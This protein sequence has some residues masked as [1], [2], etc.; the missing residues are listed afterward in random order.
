MENINVLIVEDKKSVVEDLERRLKELEYS[1]CAAVPSGAEA[2]EKAAEMQPDVV[3][4]NVELEGEIDGIETAKQ[5]RDS[6]DIPTVYLAD[7]SNDAFVEKK[8]LLKRAEITNPFDYI[9]LPHGRRRMYLTVEST[10]YQHKME[11]ETKLKE[12][13]LS[14]ILNSIS[15][16]VIA[17]DNQ[18][19]VTFMNPAA[20]RLTGWQ[21]EEAASV[22]IKQIF[23]IDNEEGCPITAILKNILNTDPAVSPESPT[24]VE[25]KDSTVFTSKS[26]RKTHIDYSIAPSIN[27]KGKVVGTVITFRDI[28]GQ[29]ALE[30]RLNQTIDQ[31]Q[32]QTQL[33]ETIFDSMSDG[34]IAAD[35]A[36]RYLMTNPKAKEITGI[37][38]EG[39]EDIPIA[40]R[41]ERYGLF[42]PDGKTLFSEDE[43]P[44]IRACRGETIDNIEMV[45]SNDTEA[46][47]IINVNGRPLLDGQGNLTGGVIVLRD[48]TELKIAQTKLE[49][50]VSEARNQSQLMETIFNSISDGVMAVDTDGKYLM[51]NARV[52]E[53]VGPL[54]E[55]IPI[56][57]RPKHYGLFYPDGKTLF[58]GDELPI[59]RALRGETTNNIEILVS[60]DSRA[61]RIININGRPLLDEQG[62]LKG[63]VIVCRDTTELKAAQTKLEQTV[64]E[65]RDKTQLIE[66]V[67]D[68]MSDGIAVIGVTGQVMLVNPSIKRMLGTRPVDKLP[69]NWSEAYGVFYPDKERHIPIDQFLS[70]HIFRGEAI[71]DKEIFVRNEGQTDGIHVMASALPLFGENREVIGCVAILRDI[72]ESKI[73]EARLEQTMQEL[74][75]QVQ[76]T[77]IVFNSISDGVVVTDEAGNFLLVNPSAE[78]IVGMGPTDT[79]PDQWSDAYGT[80]YP[81]KVTPFP[82]E[83][84]PLIKAMQG[85]VTDEIDLFMRNPENPEGCFINV[86]G[87]PLQDERNRVRGGVIV[88]RD[89]TKAKNTEVRLEQTIG[90]LE[91]QTQLL[92]TVFNSM[93]DGVV[94]LDTTGQ[95]LFTN[96]S[97]ELA[98]IESPRNVDSSEWPETYGIFY[99]DQETPVPTDQMPVMRALRG[100]EIEDEEFF[101]RNIHNNIRDRFLTDGLFVAASASPLLDK[102]QQIIGSVG[103]VRDITEQKIATIQLQQTMQ[104]LQDQTQLMDTIFNNMSDGVVVADE[105]GEYIMANP[106]AEKV[107]GQ[108]LEPL[109]LPRASEQYGVFHST[110]KSLFP[111]DQLPLAQAVKGEAANNVEMRVNNEHLSQ[112]VYISV[113]GRPLLDEQGV[114]RG[115]VVVIRDVT[116]LKQTQIQLENQTQLLE[117]VFN[118]MSDGVIVADENGE[119]IMANPAAEQM[120]GQGYDAL[121]LDQSS[122]QYG[123]FDPTT[124]SLFTPDR[125]PLTRAVKGEATDN[126]EMCIRNPHL[127]QE[128]YVSVNGRP[129]LDEQGVSRGGLVVAHNIT[130]LKQIQ[131]QLENQTQLLETIFN[132]M[133]DGVVVADEN[134]EYIMANP[135]AEQMNGQPFDELDLPRA[136]EQYGVFDPTTGSLFPPDQLPLTRAVRG[137][138][139]N[140]VEMQVK[141]EY[142][143]DIYLSINGRPLLDEKGVSRGGVVVAHNITEL[144]QTQLQL[145]QTVTELEN[146]TQL[147]EIVFN[148]MSDGVVVADDK[149]QYVMYNQTA[150]RMTGQQLAPMAIKDAPKHFGFFFP[151]KKTTFPADQLP[152]ARAL[153]G[154]GTDNVNLFMYNSK[155]QEGLH[156]S[157]SARPLRNA[158]GVVTGGVSVSRDVTKLRQAEI[159]LQDLVRQLEE[160]GN[161]MESIF[162]SISDGVVVA[163][164]DG[165]F[166]IFNPSAEKIVGLGAVD[167]TSDHWSDAYGLFFPDRVTPFPSEE[168]P[169]SLALQGETSDDVEMFVRNPN[170]PDGVFI[171]VSGRP[172][173]DETGTDKGGVAV[174]RDVTHRVIA[175]EAL[176]QA[177]AQGRLEIVET[178]LHNIGNAINSVTVGMNVLQETLVGNQLI[179]RFSALADMVKAH[180]EDWADFIKNDPKGQ[181]VLPFMIALAADFTDQNERV[182]KTLER[183]G[184]RVTHIIDII[185]T[186]RSSNQSSMVR[187]TIDLQQAILGAVKLQQ[188]S[189]D[190]RGIQVDVDCENAP[191]EI[192]IQESQF[193]Q[194]LVNL[195]KN[196]VEAIDDRIRSDGPNETPRIEIK[197]YTDADFLCLDVTDNGI[198]IAPKDLKLIFNA[199]YTTKELGTGLGLHSSANFVIGSGGKIQPLSE[200][201]GKG[202]TMRIMMRCSSI[203]P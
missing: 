185:R 127:S 31:L 159:E 1:V 75:N 131:I 157:T 143:N 167:T 186:Q 69:S 20:E 132:S 182:V 23:R 37:S 87:R 14:T 197:A 190:K 46:E 4:I 85:Q 188:D 146:Q 163:D 32:D 49:Q 110:T 196:S 105:N 151:D 98:C 125:L 152:L 21:L 92:D 162:N 3:L 191:Q 24:D 58:P 153:R 189:I 133:S 5:I 136:S 118:S 91:R 13:Q 52:E 35:T 165:A 120:T 90:S 175:E 19:L 184:E 26:G 8:D 79:P 41:S 78:R 117:T 160:Q 27:Q 121:D 166:T 43:L 15:D 82:N 40:E 29:K 70:T 172:I 84:L 73:A 173:R 9:P 183:V 156:L 107:V 61:E 57:D 169:L 6:L 119:Y 106:A 101:I 47:R 164:E 25:V 86:T 150:E 28:T 66:T 140:N 129:L 114:S 126:I 2:V 168:L 17:T 34:M 18:E 99:V 55:D 11:R 39:L 138:S 158:Q 142:S 104:E 195:L 141:N 56:T 194:M 137:E 62:N 60:N 95:V 111:S 68:T 65:L 30:E 176:M 115:G 64:S 201:I 89:V 76:L 149:G 51:V 48:M 112:E 33:M 80:F 97:V 67:F 187:K 122:E 123:L 36:G 93:N 192:K 128:V 50:A 178:I 154:E 200:G 139:T 88:F 108:S 203:M 202:A 94:V 22:S 44:L 53:M 72:T 81:D 77:E 199:G 59:T 109:D 130:E 181:Q 103:I 179:N 10:V 54:S 180:Q 193:Q 83:E 102:D 148:N 135:A 71:R 100:E 12:Q 174:F 7:Y 74:Q 171:S 116:E 16:A 134:G 147:L 155:M 144:K 96:S 161:L 145:E 42:H 177:F 63:G 170:V 198:G 38:L 113:N 45:V 124:E